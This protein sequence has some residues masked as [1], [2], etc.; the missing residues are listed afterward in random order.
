MNLRGG[1]VLQGGSTLTQQLVKNLYLTSERTFSRKAREAVLATLL[2][3]RYSKRQILQAYLNE[4]YLGASNNVSLVG[5][6]AAA[7]AY[8]GTEVSQLDLPEAATLAGMIQVPARYM[9]TREPAASKQRRDWVLDRMA[10]AGF[11]EPERAEA[12]KKT[13]LATH[14]MPVTRHRAPYFAD[15][16]RREAAQRYDLERA[17]WHRLP[18]LLDPRLERPAE[19]AGGGAVGRRGAR[20]RLG[21]GPQGKG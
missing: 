6:G 16:V 20:E 5:V 2:E 12:A 19:G 9:P 4:I 15:H 3:A 8:F 21:E 11:I 7:H 13:P 1:E 17:G 14:P 10:E 18:A